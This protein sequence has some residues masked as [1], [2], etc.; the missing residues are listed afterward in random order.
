MFMTMFKTRKALFSRRVTNKLLLAIWQLTISSLN[1]R[2]VLASSK[3]LRGVT[4][5][6]LRLIEA[7]DRCSCHL[8]SV[9]SVL[10][11]TGLLVT[12]ELFWVDRRQHLGE[13]LTHSMDTLSGVTV[14]HLTPR[15][16]LCFLAIKVGEVFC[17]RSARETF[18]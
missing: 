17:A 1:L 13:A 7:S 2:L 14:R 18:G 12:R 9:F 15:I 3:C 11:P 8:I 5:C 6:I 10:E 16:K 4:A